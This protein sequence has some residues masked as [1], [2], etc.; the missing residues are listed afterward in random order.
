MEKLDLTKIL[1][2][3]PKGWKFYS[4]IFG[5]ETYLFHIDDYKGNPCPIVIYGKLGESITYGICR[6]GNP[7]ADNYG[8]CCLFPSREMRD[9]SKF[10]A[11][12]YKKGMDTNSMSNKDDERLRKIAIAFLKDFAEQGYENAVECIDWLEKQGDLSQTKHLVDI[13]D[14]APEHRYWEE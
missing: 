12:W 11:P 6:N 7:F 3:C 13:N 14:E 1:K 5:E 10:T 2:N 8:E 9:W 4:T